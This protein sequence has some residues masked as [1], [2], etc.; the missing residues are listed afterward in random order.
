MC[1]QKCSQFSEESTVHL[2]NNP[3][4]LL[5]TAATPPQMPLV[6]PELEHDPWVPYSSKHHQIN[7]KSTYSGKALVLIT[8]HV[9]P[10][11]YV[12]IALPSGIHSEPIR[13][14]DSRTTLDKVTAFLSHLKGLNPHWVAI[15]TQGW[16][17]AIYLL[18]SC[19]G[20]SLLATEIAKSHLNN[21]Y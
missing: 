15:V 4:T 21:I 5:D 2:H 9:T 3:S 11:Y 18:Y 13:H 7:Q 19:T 10:L 20:H 12:E 17:K 8:R 16:F 6:T 14:S 1:Q